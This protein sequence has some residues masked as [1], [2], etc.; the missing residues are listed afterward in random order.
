MN[1][2]LPTLEEFLNCRIDELFNYDPSEIE[3]GTASNSDRKFYDIEDRLCSF[4]L[5][6][7]IPPFSGSFI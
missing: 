4:G 7:D 6:S 1:S 2:F 3:S 5:I